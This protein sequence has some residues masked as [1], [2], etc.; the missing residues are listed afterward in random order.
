MLLLS[1]VGVRQQH[2]WAD[3]SPKH[4]YT[5]AVHCFFVAKSR[6]Y[7]SSLTLGE[8]RFISLGVQT[9]RVVTGFWE[10]KVSEWVIRALSRSW[11][12]CSL[13]ATGTRFYQ[14]QW[15]GRIIWTLILLWHFCTMAITAILKPY[16]LSS[17]ASSFVCYDTYLWVSSQYSQI[18]RF[19]IRDFSWLTILKR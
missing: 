3:K 14:A 1:L 5:Q 18:L 6:L 19:H 17:S 15:L 8:V 9:S 13:I 2:G 11:Q 4:S 10:G 12:F 7:N 16:T